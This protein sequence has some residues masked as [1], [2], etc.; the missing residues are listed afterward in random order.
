MTR[1]GLV[2]GTDTG[3]TEEIS[4]Q[5]QSAIDWAEV[6]LHDVA[7]VKPEDLDPYNILILGVPTWDFGGIQVDWEEYWPVL[8]TMDFTG[9]TV[10]LFGLGDQFGYSN[11]FLDAMGLLHDVVVDKGAN[12]V[13]HF[14][15]E[16]FEF[17]ESK[18]LAPDGKHFVGLGL[19]EDQQM[20]LTEERL[21]RWLDQIKSELS[22]LL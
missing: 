4:G 5:I 1:I 14:S 9:K 15:T 22:D 16:G 12:I 13:G 8:E 3:N 7:S 20:E 6:E 21:A 18:A 2:F 11:Y 10:A 17:D 19:D